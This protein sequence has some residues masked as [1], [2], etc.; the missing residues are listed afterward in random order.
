MKT[1]NDAM[2]QNVSPTTRFALF[3]GIFCLFLSISLPSQSQSL[4]DEASKSPSQNTYAA[5]SSVNHQGERYFVDASFVAPLS[6]C[7]G[8][9]FLTDYEGAKNIPGVSES[10]ILSRKGNVTTVARVARE[11]FLMVPIELRSVIE[12]TPR[13]AD[14]AVDFV[15]LSGDNRFYQGTWQLRSQEGGTLFTYR[16]EVEPGSAFPAWVVEYFIEKRMLKR[17]QT[18]AERAT[19]IA[20][21]QANSCN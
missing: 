5:K 1:A 17:V 19:K 9:A 7:Q 16:S 13:P 15:Q 12:Y 2:T 14:Y 21:S 3:A 18:M 20:P 11:Q 10:R 8:F 4:A 6:L